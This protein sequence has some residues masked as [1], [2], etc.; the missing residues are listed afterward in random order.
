MGT[1]RRGCRNGSRAGSR[2]GR[3]RSSGQGRGCTDGMMLRKHTRHRGGKD[4]HP[5]P[6]KQQVACSA[7]HQSARRPGCTCAGRRGGGVGRQRVTA[8]RPPALPPARPP[9]RPPAF[10]GLTFLPASKGSVQ[11]AKQGRSS[12][13]Q[14]QQQQQHSLGQLL[15]EVGHQSIGVRVCARAPGHCMHEGRGPCFSCG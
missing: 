1:G 12:H 14:Q 7:T 4:D 3:W 2:A 8:C 6:T 5:P 13:A 15:Q 10:P 9:A 11:A